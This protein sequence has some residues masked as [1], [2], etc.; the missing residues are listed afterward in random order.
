M[1]MLLDRPA[2]DTPMRPHRTPHPFRAESLRGVVPWSGLALVLALA[3][4]LAAKAAEWQGSWAETTRALS[5]VGVLLGGPLSLAA[6]CWQGGRERRRRTDELR[7]CAAR[8]ALAQFLTSALPTALWI[9]AAYAV[10][11]AAAL[12]A[13][14]PY[15]SPGGLVPT[16]FLGTAAVLMSC[17]L[18]GHVAGARVP[19]RLTAPVLAL[20][21]YGTFGAFI[22]A[23]GPVRLL[24]PAPGYSPDHEVLAWWHPLLTAGWFLGLALAVTAAHA[25]RRRWTTLVPLAVALST[26]LVLSGTSDTMA[27]RDPR[28]GHQV[29]T[30]TTTPQICVNA[31]R[32][33]LLPEVTRALS[34]LTGRLKDVRNLPV[35]FEDLHRRP[36]ADET[37]LPMLTPFGWT[38]VR[39]RIA[40]P[41]HYA[42]EAAV[43]LVEGSDCANATTGR[44]RTVDDAVV[45]WLA[46]TDGQES[47]RKKSLKDARAERD[48]AELRRLK[49]EQRTYDHLR[50]M[51]TAERHAWLTSYFEPA[52]RCARTASEVPAL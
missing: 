34:N 52:D 8:P 12:L 21:G 29:C 39:G 15:A 19:W 22:T 48:R 31:T 2:A 47:M 3:W 17:T 46:P 33:A 5:L 10:T 38:V 51:T 16:A 4:A 26:A 7:A 20:A 44:V 18:I 45:R 27:Q 14:A 23:A 24:G 35:R 41:D 30:R 13:C 11:V 37:A 32:S 40:D 1:T 49:A 9:V 25:A 36:H 42:W 43:T 6:G 28:A 50:S